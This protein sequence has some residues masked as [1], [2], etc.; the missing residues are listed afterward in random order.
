MSVFRLCILF[1]ISVL[2]WCV[3]VSSASIETSVNLL[4]PSAK[5]KFV[6]S[7]MPRF[8]LE[9]CVFALRLRF[10][11]LSFPPHLFFFVS[12]RFSRAFSIIFPDLIF[13]RLYSV[14]VFYF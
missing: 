1:I 11:E 12:E 8:I 7:A 10:L 6:I 5:P 13:L 14:E 4:F 9:S 3:R 2:L